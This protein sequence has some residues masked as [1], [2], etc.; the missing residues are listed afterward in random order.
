[1]KYFALADDVFYFDSSSA[2]LMVESFL[3]FCQRMMLAGFVRNFGIA[4]N[5]FDSKI[6]QVK[7]RFRVGMQTQLAS[8]V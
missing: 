3:F 4:V 7:H 8:F 1:M 5:L 2:V 6:T